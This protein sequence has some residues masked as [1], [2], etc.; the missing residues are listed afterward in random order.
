MVLLLSIFEIVAITSIKTY[1]ETNDLNFFLLA[2]LFYIT[3]CII[4]YYALL[5]RQVAIVTSLWN[6][7]ET[8]IIIAIGYYLFNEKLVWYEILGIIFIIVGMLLVIKY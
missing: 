2:I 1:Q 7:L 8:I 4:L 3:V 6:G 5:L